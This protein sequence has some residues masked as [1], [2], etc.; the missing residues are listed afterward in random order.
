MAAFAPAVGLA[1]ATAMQGSRIACND[2]PKRRSGA[3]EQRRS[4]A[5]LQAKGLEHDA[6]QQR[7]ALLRVHAG[8]D[9]G[10]R[11]DSREGDQAS[12]DVERWHDAGRAETQLQAN[13]AEE[14]AQRGAW[15]WWG[16]VRRKGQARW[17]REGPGVS[18]G[19]RCGV[20][21]VPG[22]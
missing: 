5:H 15:R 13:D 14:H 1:A 12:W 4:G 9:G 21:G 6:V 3:A 16:G 7:R 18:C 22:L 2:T 19:L 10:Q 8:A 11:L 17:G 20:I